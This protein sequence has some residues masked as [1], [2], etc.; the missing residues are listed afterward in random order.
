MGPAVPMLSKNV[1][2]RYSW[3]LIEADSWLRRQ[4]LLGDQ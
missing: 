2:H 4:P 3:N 1:T